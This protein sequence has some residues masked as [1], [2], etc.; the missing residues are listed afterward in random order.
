MRTR[1]IFDQAYL[2]WRAIAFPVPY[3]TAWSCH[4]N[5]CGCS[6]KSPGILE[7][8]WQP[9]TR[10]FLCYGRSRCSGS[11]LE[12]RKERRQAGKQDGRKNVGVIWW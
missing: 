1:W 9:T 11:V 7:L 5:C 10:N 8:P 6:S 12:E 3:L 2:L 4:G